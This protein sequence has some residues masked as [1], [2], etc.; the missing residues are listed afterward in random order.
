MGEKSQRVT[1][2]TCGKSVA[3]YS[4]GIIRPHGWSTE[5]ASPSKPFQS[6]QWTN[7]C[8]GSGKVAKV[9]ETRK[10]RLNDGDTNDRQG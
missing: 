4:T 8:A 6:Y 3:I 9:S 2:Q 1:C 7:P 5:A 10:T